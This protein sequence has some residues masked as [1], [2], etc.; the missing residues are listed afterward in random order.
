MPQDRILGNIKR[1]GFAI[2]SVRAVS[3]KRMLVDPL[4]LEDGQFIL[5]LCHKVSS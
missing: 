5:G 4:T 2:L 1:D 3:V